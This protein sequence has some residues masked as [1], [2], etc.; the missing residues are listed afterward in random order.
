MGDNV[1]TG[2]NSMINP[3]IKIG[4]NSTIGPGTIIYEDIEKNKC[5]L[6]K[7]EYSE[8]EWENA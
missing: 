1:H 3:G 5:V 4:P 2:L 8:L 7:Q 6:A